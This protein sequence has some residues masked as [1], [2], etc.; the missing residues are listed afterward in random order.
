MTHYVPSFTTINGRKRRTVCGVWVNVDEHSAEPTCPEC[1]A[2]L[3]QEATTDADDVA[4]QALKDQP[5]DRSQ[6]IRTILDDPLKGYRPKG[7][8]T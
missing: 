8:K 7:S 1:Q 4:V 6:A 3:A 2:W 5:F